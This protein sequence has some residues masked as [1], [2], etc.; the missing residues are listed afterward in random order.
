LPKLPVSIGL[1]I[2]DSHKDECSSDGDPERYGQQMSTGLFE[3]PILNS[4]Y[5]PPAWHHALGADGQPLDL[6]PAA[7]RRGSKLITPVPRSRKKQGKAAQTS[8][9]LPDAKDLSTEDQEY[10]PAWIINE[11][12]GHVAIW[13]AIPNPTDRGVTPLTLTNWRHHQFQTVKPF[14]DQAKAVIW[15]TE[16]ARRDCRQDK[17]RKHLQAARAPFADNLPI[18]ELPVYRLEKK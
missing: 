3:K 14:S 10:D 5:G 4:P 16:A 17:F 13:Q 9:V 1:H 12:C 11:I 7:G 6:P 18:C 2:F 8:L 15:L